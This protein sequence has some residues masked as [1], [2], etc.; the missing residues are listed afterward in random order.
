VVGPTGDRTE[1]DSHHAS[2]VTSVKATSNVPRAVV[3]VSVL[4]VVAGVYSEY[5]SRA[6]LLKIQIS[7]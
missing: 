7:Q 5:V 6:L 4:K 2:A 1:A 3:W